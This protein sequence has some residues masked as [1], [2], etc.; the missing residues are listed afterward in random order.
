MLDF[1]RYD[2]MTVTELSKL[3]P[4]SESMKMGRLEKSRV[5]DTWEAAFNDDFTHGE[6]MYQLVNPQLMAT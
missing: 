1:D 3:W 5:H 2:G 6:T 4:N